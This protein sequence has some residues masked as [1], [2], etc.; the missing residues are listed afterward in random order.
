MEALI[1]STAAVAIAE[2]GDKTQLL[3]LFLITRYRK[4]W[5]IVAGVL[6]ATLVN[7]G[8]SAWLGSWVA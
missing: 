8:L 3:T 4:P 2:I 7:H 1:S 5:P 6:L